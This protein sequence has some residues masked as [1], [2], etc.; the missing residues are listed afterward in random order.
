[1]PRDRARARREPS[2]GAS[3]RWAHHETQFG[4][5]ARGFANIYLLVV[6]FEGAFSELYVESAVVHALPAIEQLLLA[7]PPLD[8]GPVAQAA[9]A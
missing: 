1:M 8:P 2:R 7:L 4:Y 9:G 6:V 5:F 3:A